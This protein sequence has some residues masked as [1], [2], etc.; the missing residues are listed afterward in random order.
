MWV[1]L[2]TDLILLSFVYN[3]TGLHCYNCLDIDILGENAPPIDSPFYLELKGLRVDLLFGGVD[4]G[5]CKSPSL[6]EC[7]AGQTCYV[8]QA[9]A[10]EICMFIS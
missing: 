9:E 1:A 6:K 5:S 2:L 3:E 8:M 7:D 4:P 10:E